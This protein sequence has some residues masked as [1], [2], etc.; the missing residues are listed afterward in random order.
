MFTNLG[1][2][3]DKLIRP[4]GDI[5]PVEPMTVSSARRLTGIFSVVEPVE[6]R[7]WIPPLEQSSWLGLESG[8]PLRPTRCARPHR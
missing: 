5:A 2:I 1:F 7:L 8:R 4:S 6:A 3:R